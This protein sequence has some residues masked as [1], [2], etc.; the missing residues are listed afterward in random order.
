MMVQVLKSTQ[1]LSALIVMAIGLNGLI[2]AAHRHALWD[3]ANLSV[4]GAVCYLIISFN[5]FLLANQEK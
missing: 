1:R 2:S 5:L 4:P 3:I